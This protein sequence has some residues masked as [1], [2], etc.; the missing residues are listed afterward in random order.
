MVRRFAAPQA[1][2]ATADFAPFAGYCVSCPTSL[3]GSFHWSAVMRP[4]PLFFPNPEL[5]PSF[6]TPVSCVTRLFA[7]AFEASMALSSSPAG[8]G[9]CRPPVVFTSFSFA[10]WKTPPIPPLVW[11]ATG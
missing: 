5:A 2:S 3:V 1:A 11:G 9:L 7:L 8:T 4:C 10:C 6:V